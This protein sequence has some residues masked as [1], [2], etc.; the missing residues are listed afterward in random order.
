M[1]GCKG[2]TGGHLIYT[3][4]DETSI[5]PQKRYMSCPAPCPAILELILRIEKGLL[6][7]L[8]LLNYTFLGC[9]AT[10]QIKQ[11]LGSCTAPTLS[12]TAQSTMTLMLQD[13][14]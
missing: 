11:K 9:I 2:S 13:C 10:T 5:K 4:H 6:H 14:S 12:N 8:L 1:L 7:E 3:I